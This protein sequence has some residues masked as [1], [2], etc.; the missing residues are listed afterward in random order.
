[1]ARH[2]SLEL[3]RLQIAS[4]SADVQRVEAP[5]DQRWQMDALWQDSAL[6]PG[7]FPGTGGLERGAGVARWVKGFPSGTRLGVELDAQRNLFEDVSE[8]DDPLYRTS[9]AVT[10]RQSLWRNAFGAADQ[11]RLRYARGRLAV[12]EAEHQR[13]REEVSSRVHDLYWQVVA[14]RRSF[15]AQALVVARLERLWERNRKLVEDGMLD[16]SAALAVEAALAVAGVDVEVSR[17]QAAAL[18]EQ[19]KK[20]IDLPP[21]SWAFIEIDYRV[22]VES[23]VL[24]M[25]DPLDALDTAL[26]E[27]QDLAAWRFEERRVEELIALRQQDNRADIEVGGSIGRGDAD[28]EWDEARDFD[29][30]VWSVS[31]TLDMP[32][33]QSAS[34]ADLIQAYLERDRIRVSRESLEADIELDVRGAWRDADTARRLDEATRRALALQAEKLARE[35]ERF[36]RGQSDTKTILDYENDRDLAERDAI[37]ARTGWERAWVRLQLAQ[38]VWLAGAA[39]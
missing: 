27:R 39:P 15:D 26:R 36:E 28:T 7:S 9:A 23:V 8:N 17:H 6:P 13:L 20:W 16:A 11:A 2:P 10:L 25:P 5:Y 4:A 35:L 12:L 37:R 14:A 30:T 18:D 19:L 24:P 29:R 33:E 21:R 31:A 1:L 3:H 38:G 34:R 32:V 22:P